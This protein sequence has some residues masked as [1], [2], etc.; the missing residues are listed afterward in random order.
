MGLIDKAKSFFQPESK[1]SEKNPVFANIE[2]ASSSTEP[3]KHIEDDSIFE[4]VISDIKSWREA[5]EM[6]DNNISPNR[7]EMQLLYREASIDDMVVTKFNI[8]TERIKGTEYEIAGAN[9]TVDEDK[10]VILNSKWFNKIIKHYVES[11]F[12]GYTL[13]QIPLRPNPDSNTG[14]LYDI[15][16]IKLIPRTH[17]VPEWGGIRKYTYSDNEILYYTKQKY[18]NRLIE[19][20]DIDE[21]GLFV[22]IMPHYIYK[23]N[24]LF[25]WSGY[26]SKFGITPI[27]VKTDLDDSENTDKLEEFLRSMASNSYALINRHDEME[28]LN[29]VSTDASATFEKMKDTCD[30]SISRIIDGGTMTSVQ[31]SSR[32]QA[33]VHENTSELLHLGRLLE[34]KRVINK[35]LIPKLIAQGVLAEGDYFRIKDTKD[36]DAI[37]SRILK[38]SQ[39]GYLVS[40]ELIEELTGFEVSA[41]ISSPESDGSTENYYNNEKLI[42]LEETLHEIKTKL[43]TTG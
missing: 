14:D 13:V 4:H 20:N 32:S 30:A 25:F 9:D 3:T 19:F 21:Y 6:W 37:I 39:A 7:A 42:R 1:R 38:L 41:N 43:T 40:E 33:E 15:R 23:K 11:I 24:A 10:T 8:L 18:M 29:G 31:G 5:L 27:I 12:Y 36:I 16:D 17:V 22:S 2:N 28:A 26:Q 35:Q 34:F